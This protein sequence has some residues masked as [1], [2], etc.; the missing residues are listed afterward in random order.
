MGAAGSLALPNGIQKWVFPALNNNSSAVANRYVAAPALV[1]N[2]GYPNAYTCGAEGVA[3]VVRTAT[4]LWTVTLQDQYQRLLS[5]S[6]HISIAGGLS[7]IV[8]VA[9][10]TTITN[11]LPG[12]ANVPSIIGVALLSSTGTAADPTS[13]SLVHI[14]FRL[15]NATEP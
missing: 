14:H 5:M 1:T 9:E 15:G 13:G 4:G 8:A 11:M 10:N 3:G 12:V 7:N 6:V 2:L